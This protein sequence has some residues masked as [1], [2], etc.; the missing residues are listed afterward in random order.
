MA[1]IKKVMIAAM[2]AV[3]L[4]LFWDA[5]WNTYPRLVPWR[6]ESPVDVDTTVLMLHAVSHACVLESGE[7][8]KE[9]LD[10]VEVHETADTVTIET[11]L[12]PSERD[13]FQIGC[14]KGVGTGF[15]VRVVLDS[16][17]G[18][19]R[20][21]DPACTFDRFANWNVCGD[22]SGNGGKVGDRVESSESDKRP[23]RPPRKTLSD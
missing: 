7:V 13:G 18:N 2:I 8:V 19:R 6:L 10:R 4:V 22:S 14:M 16:P 5:V 12:G 3:G 21:V 1:R 17:L 11:W 20:F 9:T 23:H 15:S